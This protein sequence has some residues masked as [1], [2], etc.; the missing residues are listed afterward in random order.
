M[1][2]LLILSILFFFLNPAY[3]Q[4]DPLTDLTGRRIATLLDD[5]LTAGNHH[6]TWDAKD[7]PA[8]MYLCRMEAGGF[9]KTMKMVLVK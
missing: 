5:R 2:I 9:R 4:Q 8:G 3:S 6:L 1:R 7:Y